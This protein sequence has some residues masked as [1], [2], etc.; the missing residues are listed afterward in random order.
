MQ[1]KDLQM[2][3]KMFINLIILLG[4]AFCFAEKIAVAPL[5][6]YDNESSK[7]VIE[8]DFQENLS[9]NLINEWFEGLIEFNKLS[10][11]DYGDVYTTLDANKVCIAGKY[12]YLIYGFIQKNENSWFGNI[13]L[14]SV[15]AK[16]IVKE[17][18]ASDDIENMER[19][20]QVLKNNVIS[21]LYEITGLDDIG[22]KTSDGIS[23]KIN[24]L[25][26]G[27]YWHPIGEKWSSMYMGVGGGFL[28]IDFV[29]PQSKKTLFSKL[30]YLSLGVGASYAYG[31][32]TEKSYPLKLQTIQI[33]LPIYLHLNFSRYNSLFFRFAPYY[34]FEFL[35][36]I[37]KYKEEEMYQQVL[38]GLE[39][40]I[41]YEFFPL[42]WFSIYLKCDYSFHLSP[43]NFSVIKPGLGFKFKLN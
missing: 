14:F 25:L 21:G 40:G 11:E 24:L 9:K 19:F 39:V 34:E 6:T 17:F 5:I 1:K 31:K 8:Y 28:G 2:N 26:D 33:M 43:D 35:N 42:D 12:D 32:E 23:F 30:I 36:I 7:I 18:F 41:G 29:P 20:F 22:N 13:K 10:A 38:P 16:K 37:Q 4:S 15:D 27:F 3:K